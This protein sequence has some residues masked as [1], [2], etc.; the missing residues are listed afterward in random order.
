MLK[1]TKFYARSF[2]IDALTIW[3]EIEDVSLSDDIYAYEFTLLKSESAAGPFD[4]VYGPFQ[5]IFTFRDSVHPTNHKNTTIYYKLRIVD[6]RIDGDLGVEYGPTAQIPE[7][8]LEA[9]EII[10]LEDTLFRNVTG[11]KWYVFPRKTFGARCIC[12][13]TTMQRQEFGNC[14]TCFGVG[15]LGA[16]NQPIAFYGQC[17]PTSRQS[18]LGVAINQT[19]NI[20]IL[21]TVSYPSI[22]PGDL[23]VNSENHRWYC[24]KTEVTQRLGYDVH[25]EITI[26]EILRSNVE[27]LVPV[28][29][30]IKNI[31]GITDPRLFSNPQ[32]LN[33]EVRPNYLGDE[34]DGIVY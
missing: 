14:K 22:L 21:R 15:Y 23:L 32:T 5:N 9:L 30:S 16:Y 13:N 8:N 19:P 29:D 1:L 33:N 7:P 2:E 25:Q 20:T 12:Y 3:W 11:R 24:I 28:L 27:Y 6:R 10:R 34:P 17:D 31:E 26:K 18:Q 4:I